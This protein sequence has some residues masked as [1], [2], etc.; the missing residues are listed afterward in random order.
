MIT[1]TGRV[2]GVGFRWFTR[3]VATRHGLTGW[4]RNTHDGGVETLLHGADSEVDAVLAALRAGPTHARVDDV[5]MKDAE[6]PR[7]IGFEIRR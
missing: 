6:D 4:V 7:L 3:D 1:V 5:T 2:Q